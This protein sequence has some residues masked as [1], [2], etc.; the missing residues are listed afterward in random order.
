M[1]DHNGQLIKVTS[2]YDVVLVE[3][4]YDLYGK[5]TEKKL[6]DGEGIRYIYNLKGKPV[7]AET[8]DGIR[9]EY[10]YDA[11][12]NLKASA[13]GKQITKYENDIWGRV[14]KIMA[15]EGVTESYKYDYKGNITEATDGEGK[16]TRYKVN[17]F[18]KLCELTYADGIKETF[19][20]D[21]EGNL[22]THI[23]RSGIV[24]NYN[25]EEG[26]E[27]ENFFMMILE[28]Y[29]KSMGLGNKFKEITKQQQN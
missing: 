16:S 1:Y 26:G 5:V 15:P 19:S 14:T 28:E 10:A 6:V 7:I 9:E 13:T 27:V 18:G 29:S 20:Y 12:G 21:M 8:K 2:P 17:T 24:L 22:K 11:L 4:K 25:Y 3:N 23:K